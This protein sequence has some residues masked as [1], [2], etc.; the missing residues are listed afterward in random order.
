MNCY[1]FEIYTR[2]G[3]T[4]EWVNLTKQEAS[5]LYELTTKCSMGNIEEFRWY[6]RDDQ[7]SRDSF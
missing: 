5:K 7:L 3:S 4:V 1:C 2:D 6:K